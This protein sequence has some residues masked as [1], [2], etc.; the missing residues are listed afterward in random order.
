MAFLLDTNHCIYFLNGLEKP[1]EKRSERE[2]RVIDR[3]LTVSDP[4][5]FLSEATLGELYYGVARSQRQA[6]NREKVEF[7][8]RVFTQIAVTEPVWQCFGETLAV[9][10][11]AGTPMGE[12][13]LLIACTARVHR[14][15]L[16]TSDADF[17]LLPADFIERADWTTP[18]A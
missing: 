13:D 9:L 15:I 17:D 1:P 11:Q 10:R 4:R 6:E 2:Q 18:A 8:K 5:I 16:V 12:R 3:V 7:L 14:Q